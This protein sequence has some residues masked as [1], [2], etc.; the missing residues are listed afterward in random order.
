MAHPINRIMLE[1]RANRTCRFRSF[2]SCNNTVDGA[3]DGGDDG[4]GSDGDDNG[5]DNG[6]N[7]WVW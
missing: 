1:L 7:R 3:D 2:V 6:D 5:G 4:G